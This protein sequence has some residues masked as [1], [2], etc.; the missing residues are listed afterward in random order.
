MRGHA[1]RLRAGPWRFVAAGDEVRVHPSEVVWLE[2][3][4]LPADAT[5]VTLPQAEPF[6]GEPPDGMPAMGVLLEATVGMSLARHG[7]AELLSCVTSLGAA[8]AG[9]D[10]ALVTVVAELEARGVDSPAGLSRVD[11]LRSVDPTL[12]A[13]QAKDVLTV[14]RALTQPRWREL[15]ARVAMQHV[16]VAKAARV[17]S[18]Y[19]EAAPVADP[20]ELAA[21]VTDLL[22]QATGATVEELSRLARHHAEQVR[23]PRDEDRLDT[24][25]VAARGLWFSPPTPT[26]MVTMRGTLDPEAAA[27]LKCAIDPLSMPCPT[28]DRH[29]HTLE[30]DPRSPAR[31]RADALVAV[32]ARGVAAA[33]KVPKTDKAKVIVTIDHEVL[34]G[35][36]GGAGVTLSGDVLSPE[37]VRRLACDAAI[38]PMVL[39]RK[40]EPLDVGRE[41]RLVTAGL[42]VALWQ[43]DQGCTFP[44][45]TIPPQWTDAHH[46]RH[47]SRG[48]RTSLLNTCLLCPRH[49]TYVHRHDLVPTV[50]ATTVTWH[51]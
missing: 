35:A 16:T 4:S 18:L 48:G 36:L 44:G 5:P 6:A 50:T 23:P 19:D 15:A 27:V 49:H 39:G 45:C 17:I 25:R 13:G 37:T 21:A 46:G 30:Q 42:R 38:I 14:A 47:W 20:E 26:G 9:H 28:K 24:G 10:V 3:E 12:S 11:W 2:H 22:S 1:T 7:E 40:S 33:E 43:R 41:W 34:T 31:R 8:R 32:V 51:P 29:G